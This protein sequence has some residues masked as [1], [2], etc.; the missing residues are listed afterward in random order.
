METRNDEVGDEAYRP[1]LHEKEGDDESESHE[2]EEDEDEEELPLPT[3][4]IRLKEVMMDSFETDIIPFQVVRRIIRESQSYKSLSVK[5]M[6]GNLPH[7][8]ESDLP[9]LDAVDD[10]EELE[11]GP[12]RTC[13]PNERHALR[14]RSDPVC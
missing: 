14:P 11:A 9:I 1:K 13:A 4:K 6:K 10:H 12:T 2:E 8:E 7:E 5:S 3:E